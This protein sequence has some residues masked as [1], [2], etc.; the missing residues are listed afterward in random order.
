MKINLDFSVYEM[1]LFKCIY[2]FI[3]KPGVVT[4]ILYKQFT[5]S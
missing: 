2:L 3:D 4:S 1:S 5:F